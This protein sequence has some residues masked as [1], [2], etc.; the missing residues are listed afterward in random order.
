MDSFSDS[1][2][3]NGNEHNDNYDVKFMQ[4]KLGRQSTFHPTT[5]TPADDTDD[6]DDNNV[7]EN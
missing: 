1:A 2:G 3:K 4:H 7:K 5:T 6:Y